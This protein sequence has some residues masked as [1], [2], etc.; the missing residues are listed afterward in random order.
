MLLLFIIGA[1]KILS[2]LFDL[3]SP[4][5]LPRLNLQKRYGGG[6]ALVTGGS[7]GIGFAIAEE[8]AKEGFNIVLISRNKGKLEDARGKILKVKSGI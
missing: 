1:G 7:E 3:I 5:I 4:F 6:W 2:F 8:L